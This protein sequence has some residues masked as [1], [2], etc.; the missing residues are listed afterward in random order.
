VQDDALLASQNSEHGDEQGL[1]INRLGVVVQKQ[2]RCS[3]ESAVDAVEW[4][5]WMW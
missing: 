3:N 5:A 4:G 2:S 1:R